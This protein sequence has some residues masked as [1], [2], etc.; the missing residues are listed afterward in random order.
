MLDSIHWWEWL[1]I[2]LGL[3][4]A[5]AL[6]MSV[7]TFIQMFA[8]RPRLNLLFE[9]I[10]EGE[11]RALLVFIKN[12]PVTHWL[13][14]RLRVRRDTV[15]SLTAQFTLSEAG[16]G[17][18]I[19]PNIEARIYSDADPDDEGR[20]RISLPPTFSVGASFIVAIRNTKEAEVVVPKSRIHPETVLIPGLFRVEIILMVDGQL[21][22]YI[23]QFV[24]GKD[25]ESLGWI[26]PK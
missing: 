11:S 17:H 5:L 14:K 6:F 20:D 26:P 2:G 8:G 9:R 18:I 13:F 12:Q 1:S 24:V 10:T 15:Q 23:R 22:R 16:S 3:A 19:I 21:T 4:G 25:P 7:P